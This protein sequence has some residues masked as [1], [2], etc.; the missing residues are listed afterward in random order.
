MEDFAHLV[1]ELTDPAKKGDYAQ[2]REVLR[3][4]KRTHFLW[5]ANAIQQEGIDKLVKM[6]CCNLLIVNL[7]PSPVARRCTDVTLSSGGGDEQALKGW[8][9]TSVNEW[10]GDQVCV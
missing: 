9:V 5:Q 1:A 6:P 10:G 8:V 4:A 2:V 3:D 7:I